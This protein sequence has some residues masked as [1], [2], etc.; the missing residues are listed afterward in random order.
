MDTLKTL[1]NI[2]LNTDTSGT[3]P[4]YDVVL[5]E[6]VTISFMFNFFFY[7]FIF[8]NTQ[9]YEVRKYRK[10]KYAVLRLKTVSENGKGVD[11]VTKH[12]WRIMKYTQGENDKKVTMKFHLPV[13][14][15]AETPEGEEEKEDKTEVKIMV[16]LPI[17]YQEYKE[18]GECNEAPLPTDTEIKIEVVEE[19]QG[20]AK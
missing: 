10:N 3:M 6:K 7:L 4:K 19:F 20:I 5:K 8:F 14:V 11:S 2:G 12:V 15:Q 17:E 16:T 9:E 1:Y 18:G 13:V